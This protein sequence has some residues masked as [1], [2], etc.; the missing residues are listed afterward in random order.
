M[1]PVDMFHIPGIILGE[2]IKPLVYDKTATQPDVLA[3]ALDLID[4]DLTYPIMGQS[5]FSDKKQNIAFMQFH[6]DYALM[7]D[8]RVAVMRPN[9]NPVTFLYQDRH[10]VKADHDEELEKNALAFIIT[11]DHLY[12]KRLYR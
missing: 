3:T 1:V 5:I 7:V 4:L 11:L 12:N 6:T 2:G 10:L 8:N 9:K